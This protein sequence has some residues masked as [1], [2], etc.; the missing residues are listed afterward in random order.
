MARPSDRLIA[1][2][3][4]LVVVGQAGGVLVDGAAHAERLR[5]AR[6]QLGELV[7]VAGDG[8]RHHDGGIVGRARDDALDRVLDRDACCPACRP[9]LVGVW[10]AACVGDLELAVELELAGLELLEQQIERHDL[11]ERGRMALRVRDWSNAAPCP[12]LASTTMVRVRRGV[13]MDCLKCENAATSKTEHTPTKPATGSGP[14]PQH[15][16]S[17]SSFPRRSVRSADTPVVP[18]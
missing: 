2:R 4:D 3:R 10:P 17:P 8:F 11:G 9:S 5:L 15:D 13:A 16:S 6:H 12:E 7:L 18:R 1:R 14:D